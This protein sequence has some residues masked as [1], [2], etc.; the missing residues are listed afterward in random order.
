LEIPQPGI[1]AKVS[2]KGVVRVTEEVIQVVRERQK[3]NDS[4]EVS[5]LAILQ[6]IDKLY[7]TKILGINNEA[8]DVNKIIMSFKAILLTK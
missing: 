6:K 1:N 3:V 2:S 7:E 8:E 4:R 5:L